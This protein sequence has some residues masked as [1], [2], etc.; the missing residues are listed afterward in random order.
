MTRRQIQGLWMI[1]GGMTL[2]IFKAFY[3]WYSTGK[4]EGAKNATATVWPELIA[5]KEQRDKAIE[6]ANSTFKASQ[7]WK[8]AADGFERAYVDMSSANDKNERNVHRCLVLLEG[9]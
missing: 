7:Q 3:F 8:I 5:V 9:K 1:V 4:V 2:L 6:A